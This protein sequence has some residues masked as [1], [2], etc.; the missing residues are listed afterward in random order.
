MLTGIITQEN[1]VV[2]SDDGYP[3]VESEKPSVPEYCKAVS[4]YTE[5]DGKIIQ[6]WEVTSQLS[7]A[8]AIDKFIALQE[9]YYDRTVKSYRPDPYDWTVYYL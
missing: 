7:K 5:T 4:R 6:S 8:E 2:L 9:V 1:T 3:I